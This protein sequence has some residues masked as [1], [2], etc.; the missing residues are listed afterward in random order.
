[1]KYGIK[2]V[3]TYLYILEN[4]PKNAIGYADRGRRHNV[5]NTQ[6][7]INKT[8]FY[9][10]QWYIKK[11]TFP[12]GRACLCSD[13]GYHYFKDIFSL[14]KYGANVGY[15]PADT[16]SQDFWV[17]EVDDSHPCFETEEKCICKKFRFVKKI[18]NKDI[19]NIVD[20]ITKRK[21][22]IKKLDIPEELK[23]K[24]GNV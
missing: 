1:M 4:C 14:L 8:I 16:D 12:A 6:P 20:H 19:R 5:T 10:N 9:N 2:V 17:I 3:C 15:P 23:I 13:W 11:N 18:P 7:F 24:G 22:L 21:S